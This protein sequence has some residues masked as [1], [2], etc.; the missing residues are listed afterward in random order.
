MRRLGMNRWLAI[1]LVLGLVLGSI[2]A[3]PTSSLASNGDVVKENPFGDPGGTGPGDPDG[4]SGPN[5][6]SP[7]GGRL[8]PG[9]NVYA[10]APVGDGGKASS[11]WSWRFHIVLRSLISWLYR[12]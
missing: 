10:A 12:Y 2:P 7:S 4:P 6:K 8:S 9:G 3:L 5:K 11:V 1:L